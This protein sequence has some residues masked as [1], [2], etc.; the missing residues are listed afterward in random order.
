MNP[1]SLIAGL[2]RFDFEAI[3]AD[4]DQLGAF[5]DVA[6]MIAE[7]EPRAREAAE[8]F[9][10]ANQEIPGWEVVRREGSRFV[11]NVHVREL[12][13]ECSVNQ[14]PTLLE[15]VSKALGNVG[16][17]R[18]QILCDA[19]GRLN[20]D[21]VVS[22]CGAT[23]F[24]RKGSRNGENQQQTERW[25]TNEKQNTQETRRTSVMKCLTSGVMARDH[26]KGGLPVFRVGDID[27]DH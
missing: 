8:K 14:L 3:L 4:P 23:V 22:Q 10:L 17:K 9:G 5:L 20:G 12:L 13:S 18:W 1:A 11:N 26:K 19:V 25:Q 7:L 15:V 21:K 6:Q 24:L 16:E 27:I 2:V